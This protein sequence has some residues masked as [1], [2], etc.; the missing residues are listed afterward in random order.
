MRM[1]YQKTDLKILIRHILNFIL[2]SNFFKF[3]VEHDKRKRTH[4]KGNI[5]CNQVLLKLIKAYLNLNLSS[6][7]TKYNS[8][9][10]ITILMNYPWWLHPY[11]RWF[12]FI[13]KTLN[14]NM[15]FWNNLSTI[16]VLLYSLKGNLIKLMM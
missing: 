1:W 7:I 2:V 9:N 12:V 8:G 4:V 14:G 15:F 13:L 16:Y 6:S 10:S 5:A 3:L 11:N